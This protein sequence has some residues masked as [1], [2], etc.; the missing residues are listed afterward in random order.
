MDS[1]W[2]FGEKLPIKRMVAHLQGEC[3]NFAEKKAEEPQ[4]QAKES[5]LFVLRREAQTNRFYRS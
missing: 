5:S 4:P 2:T 1:F 3:R